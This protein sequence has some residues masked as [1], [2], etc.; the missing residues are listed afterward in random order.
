MYVIAFCF[1]LSLGELLSH[2]GHF[3]AN[4]FLASRST[5]IVVLVEEC[6]ILPL[7][8]Q[9]VLGIVLF[10]GFTALTQTITAGS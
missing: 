2:I 3:S 1:A 5:G 10:P 4:V 6:G 9:I 7:L 8:G